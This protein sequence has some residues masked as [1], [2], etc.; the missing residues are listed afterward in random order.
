M[1]LTKVDGGEN[2]PNIELLFPEAESDQRYSSQHVATREFQHNIES[3][4]SPLREWILVHLAL[5]KICMLGYKAH[6]LN[7]DGFSR[8]C[9]DI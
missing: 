8:L 1:G 7:V 3:E 6:F 4:V 5:E 2:R 9:N